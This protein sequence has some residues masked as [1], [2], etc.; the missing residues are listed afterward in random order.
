[1]I[2]EFIPH[3]RLMNN[4]IQNLEKIVK[5]AF[6]QRRKNIKTT[7]S[8]YK[9]ELNKLKINENLRAENISVSLYCRLAETMK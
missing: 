9:L 6:G 8:E 7:L 4:K 1:M 2:I 5:L 3:N